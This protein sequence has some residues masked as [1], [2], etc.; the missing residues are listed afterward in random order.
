[1][2]TEISVDFLEGS[3]G[4]CIRVLSL[5]VEIN[6]GQPSRNGEGSSPELALVRVSAPTL[7]FA[8]DS[9]ETIIIRSGRASWWDKGGSWCA[10]VETAGLG[11]LSLG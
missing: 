11:R 4:T 6:K 1:M 10:L 2:V 7:P 3:L 5:D 8:R 9:K